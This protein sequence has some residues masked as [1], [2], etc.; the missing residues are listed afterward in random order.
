MR[1]LLI[2]LFFCLIC[3]EHAAGKDVTLM[4]VAAT[5][6]NKD[7][8]KA[9]LIYKSTTQ[10]PRRKLKV[11]SWFV[12]LDDKEDFDLKKGFVTKWLGV[13]EDKAISLGPK[14]R[15][16]ALKVVPGVYAL[17]SIITLKDGKMQRIHAQKSTQTISLSAGEVY[18]LNDV[19]FKWQAD[20]KYYMNNK[21]MKIDLSKWIDI[22]KEL[23]IGRIINLRPKISKLNR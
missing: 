3:G 13:E 9:L 14:D 16:R 12:Y 4:G 15:F 20:S 8:D 21:E 17:Q 5:S 19:I 23:N 7:S 18:F 1:V 11:I 2:G 10:H 6:F 22:N